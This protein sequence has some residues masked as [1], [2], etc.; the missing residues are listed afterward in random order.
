M[1]SS[2][3]SASRGFSLMGLCCL[4]MCFAFAPARAQQAGMQFEHSNLQATL[5]KAKAEGKLVFVDA[6]TEWCGPCKMMTRSVFP[7]PE[8]GTYFNQYYISLKLDMEK[9]EGEAF[10]QKYEVDAYPTLLVLAPDGKLVL[11]AVGALSPTD[12]VA[13]GH[14]AR[15]KALKAGQVSAK[16]G[17]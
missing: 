6:F 16:A 2:L 1:I 17:R 8:V 10:A 13:F 5:A 11:R 7:Q 3:L 14:Q 12:L 15:A 4:A 9:G